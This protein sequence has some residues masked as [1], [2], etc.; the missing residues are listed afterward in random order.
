MEHAAARI[1]GSAVAA[2]PSRKPVRLRNDSWSDDHQC[3]AAYQRSYK[4]LDYHPADADPYSVGSHGTVVAD[5]AAGNGRSGGPEGVAPESSIVFVHL[6]S[7]GTSGLANLGDSIGIL[8]GLDFISRVA[9]NRPLSMSLSVGRHGGPHDGCTPVERAFDWF[10]SSTHGRTLSQSSGN[11]GL[12]QTHASGVLNPGTS[13][14]LRLIVDAADPSLNE[15]EIWHQIDR[16]SVRFDTPDGT[17]S[18][19]VVVGA[20]ADIERAGRLIAR[21]YHRKLDPQNGSH[22]VDAFIYPGAPAGEWTVSLRD[23]RTSGEA[24]QFDAWIERDDACAAC[25]S[26]FRVE[27]ADPACTLGTLATGESTLTCGAF[28]AQ[29]RRGPLRPSPVPAQPATADRSPISLRQASAFSRHD[30]NRE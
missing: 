25:Q 24:E 28:D 10:L 6:A 19:W 14:S 22:H 4:A 5:I 9:G 3:G 13:R 1:V 7:R 27:D 20:A 30:P 16:C 23:E 11:Y 8:E 18:G 26:R 21:V 17:T 2:A 12:K 29:I 15:L